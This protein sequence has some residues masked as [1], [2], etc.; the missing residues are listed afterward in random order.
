MLN[1]LL[2]VDAPEIKRHCRWPARLV[3]HFGVNHD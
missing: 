2:I 3:D 1:K